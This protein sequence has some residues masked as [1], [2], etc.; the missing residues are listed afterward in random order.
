MGT[1][2]CSHCKVL[3]TAEGD[4]PPPADAPCPHCG[5]VRQNIA[6][7]VAPEVVTV[8]AGPVSVIVIDYATSLLHEAPALLAEQKFG[9]SIVVCTYRLGSRGTSRV[10]TSIC[11]TRDDRARSLGDGLFSGF[12]LKD[13]RVRSVYTAL[14]GDLAEPLPSW[15]RRSQRLSNAPMTSC[16]RCESRTA[17]SP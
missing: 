11:C 4:T 7:Q 6:L 17:G 8:S 10:L 16:I 1:V 5:Q 9:L 2:T 13:K 14:T 3:L 12:N 15:W